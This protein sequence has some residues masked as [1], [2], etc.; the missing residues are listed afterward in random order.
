[1]VATRDL[2]A[3]FE[4]ASL[5][6]LTDEDAP[7]MLAL[8]KL[9]EPG[10]FFEQTHRLGRFLGIR[11]EGA[12][13]AMAGERMRLPGYTEVSAVC[14]HPDCRGRGY[15][16]RL[17][18]AVAAHIQASGATPFLHAWVS[19]MPAI[20]LYEALGFSIRAE[21]QITVLEREA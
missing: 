7:A 11:V 12:L 15:A 20:R 17:S 16:R 21:L 18:A 1:M 8:A 19:N 9:T 3:N 2:R 10:P 14:T 5:D 4:R 13:A 6:L